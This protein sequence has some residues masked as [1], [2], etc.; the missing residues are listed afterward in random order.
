[1]RHLV[2]EAGLEGDV[3]LDSAGTAGYHAGEAPDPRSRAAA[4]RRGIAVD[5]TARQ[6]QRQDFERFDYVIAM[7]RANLEDLEELASE[8]TRAKLHLLRHFDPAAPSGSSVPDPYY[9]GEAGFD[10]VV[11]I[12]LAACRGLLD[13][14]RRE[15]QL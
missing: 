2:R 13:H 9:G 3:E 8:A 12:C 7:D 5:G 1:M 4:R 15:H 10:E 6:F 14:V 11:A